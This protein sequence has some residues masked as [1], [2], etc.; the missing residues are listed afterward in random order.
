MRML[1]PSFTDDEF[2]TMIPATSRL[3]LSK[4][5]PLLAVFVTVSAAGLY[6]HE[7]FLDEVQH[8]LIGRDS[9]SLSS[10]YWN[11]RYD[12]HS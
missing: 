12:G 10:M 1:S 11:M 9:N 3:P 4:T 7:L 8:F 5:L 6:Y 2:E